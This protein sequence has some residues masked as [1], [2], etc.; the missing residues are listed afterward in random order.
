MRRLETPVYDDGEQQFSTCENPQ[1]KRGPS[2]SD[3]V[4]ME[5]TCFAFPL[6]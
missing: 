2:A 1:V 3:T 6:G 5:N 4:Q